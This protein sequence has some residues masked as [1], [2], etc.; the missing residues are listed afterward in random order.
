MNGWFFNN[1]L[2][3]QSITIPYCDAVTCWVIKACFISHLG[4]ITRKLANICQQ[5]KAFVS[6]C[7][8][9]TDVPWSHCAIFLPQ[10]LVVQSTS[11]MWGRKIAWQAQEVSA[12]GYY[13]YDFQRLCQ[14]T[15]P[16]RF[17]GETLDVG[18]WITLLDDQLNNFSYQL[19]LLRCT[20]QFF[21]HKN[22]HQVH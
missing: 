12:G 19:L 15:E 16:Q 11:P 1:T 13:L 7:I 2:Y 20:Q 4:W 6:T 21:F 17:A 22:Y 9:S 14:L 8:A 18:R 3:K 10:V 5:S